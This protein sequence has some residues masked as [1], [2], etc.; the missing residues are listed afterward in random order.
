MSYGAPL[1]KYFLYTVTHYNEGRL[2]GRDE[3]IDRHKRDGLTFQLWGALPVTESFNVRLGVGPYLFFDTQ[4][5]PSTTFKQ[6]H[7]IVPIYSLAASYDFHF[8]N[9]PSFVQITANRTD[10]TDEFATTSYLLGLGLYF[11]HSVEKNAKNDS[12]PKRKVSILGGL[13]YENGNGNG[14]G[15]AF[16]IEYSQEINKTFTWSA[17]VLS[18]NAPDEGLDRKGVL[19]Q[20]WW[21]SQL[22]D[23]VGV[24]LGA[25]PAYFSGETEGAVVISISADYKLN[26]KWNLDLRLNRVA[27]N[28]N[29]E[30][31]DILLGISRSF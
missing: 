27:T 7:G 17:A 5:S 9:T 16:S 11:D 20:I 14:S 24:G 8:F 1:H 10:T 26:E 19:G 31:D 6:T 29:L 25:G 12:A 15:P 2:P 18:E 22:T 3:Q 28:K 13:S 23:S 4:V 30:T 21:K